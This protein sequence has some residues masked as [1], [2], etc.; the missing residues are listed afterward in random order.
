MS[1]TAICFDL[2]GTLVDSEPL[3][4]IAWAEELATQGAGLE[5][6]EYYHRF[7]GRSTRNNFV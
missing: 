7:S 2:D 4:Y 3:H 6:Q 1:L 5:E